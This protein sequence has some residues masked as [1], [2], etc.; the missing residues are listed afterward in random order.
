MTDITATKLH[1]EAEIR[2]SSFSANAGDC[3]SAQDPIPLNMRKRERPVI[4]DVPGEC[5]SR[6]QGILADLDE[7]PQVGHVGVT[8]RT[9]AQAPQTQERMLASFEG[10]RVNARAPRGG[11]RQLSPAPL[12][13]AGEATPLSSETL[14][15]T[16][17]NTR[18]SGTS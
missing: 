6:I 15:G 7:G 11:D 5:G 8:P 9:Q 4:S 13:V 10:Q 17:C 18:H 3:E 14:P 12:Q 2:Y 1:A 16:R